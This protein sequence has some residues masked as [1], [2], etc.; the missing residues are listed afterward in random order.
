MVAD[1]HGGRSLTVAARPFCGACE[2]D[3]EAVARFVVDGYAVVR[4]GSCG[5]VFTD[6]DPAFDAGAMYGA[7]YFEGGQ[8]VSYPGYGASARVLE[9]EFSR[10]LT[11]L[12]RWVPA[13]RLLEVGAAYGIFLRVA[14]RHFIVRGL[15]VSAAAVAIA[16][17][18]GLDARH[19]DLCAKEA[20]ELDGPFDAV[21]LLDTIEH[22]RWPLRALRRLRDVTRPGAAL[23]LTTGD[24][25]SVVARLCGRHWR[26]MT[27]PEHLFFFDRVTLAR[28]LEAA[29]FDIVLIDR[30]WKLVPLGLILHRGTRRWAP[31]GRFAR[32]L[33]GA[34]V[35]LNLFDTM[36]VVAIRRE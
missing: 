9:R 17:E 25:G 15:D 19:G 16:R 13:G 7:A 6:V 34:G 11:V 2:R 20:P 33:V 12:R 1:V 30:P 36:R 32:R 28:L 18:S 10:S 21:V 23:L 22:L 35:P 26:L 8:T 29:G 4:C 3:G 5:T 27:P 31:A 14:R 24:G